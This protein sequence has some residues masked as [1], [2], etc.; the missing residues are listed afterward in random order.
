MRVASLHRFLLSQ[1]VVRAGAFALVM[2]MAL[3]ALL[4]FG[5]IGVAAADLSPG[6]D[7]TQP[8]RW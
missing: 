7:P 8:F 4:A 6:S 1:F 5:A 2:S 3:I